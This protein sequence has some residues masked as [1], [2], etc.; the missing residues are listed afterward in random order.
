M[1]FTSRPVPLAAAAFRSVLCVAGTAGLIGTTVR[2]LTDP[3]PA[4]FWIYFTFQSN[5]LLTL[6]FAAL[7]F[8]VR[9]PG[10]RDATAFPAAKGA[11]TLYILITG[12][13]FN[14]LLA[15]PASP[16]YQVQ[17]ESH[18]TW[19]SVLLHVVTPLMALLDWLS[20]GPR[21]ALRWRHA[22]LWLSYPLVYLAFALVRGALVTTGTLYPYPFLDV[23]RSGYGL[24]AVNC[25]FLAIGFHLLGLGLV[26]VDRGL[27]AGSTAAAREPDRDASGTAAPGA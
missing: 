13:V 16:F 5:L 8:R 14:L 17:Q 19:N 11:V 23:T 4:E 15:N 18:Y 24:V 22:A 27:A 25:V 9:L 12:L 10:G 7:V 21:G 6:Y 26:A 20:F 1:P 2:S 3:G